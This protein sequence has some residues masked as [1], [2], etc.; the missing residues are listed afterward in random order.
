MKSIFLFIIFVLVDVLFINILIQAEYICSSLKPDLCIGL[1]LKEK[2][3]PKAGDKLQ[4]KSRYN[5]IL[6]GLAN[7]RL[8]W[9]LD[10]ANTN[11]TA[12][13]IY[14]IS[15]AE[16]LYIDH[17]QNSIQLREGGLF[18]KVDAWQFTLKSSRIVLDGSERCMTIMQCNLKEIGVVRPYCDP[19]SLQPEN[20]VDDLRKG[21]YVKLQPCKFGKE[22][23]VS[24][25]FGVGLDCEKGCNSTLRENEVCDEECNVQ[26]CFFDDGRCLN[27]Q[28]VTYTPTSS[29]TL[30]TNTSTNSTSSPVDDPP[31][32]STESP[33]GNTTQGTPMP[34]MQP[35]TASPE[36]ETPL[37]PTPPT[38]LPTRS[39]TRSPSKNP[40]QSPIKKKTKKPTSKP[41]SKGTS[42][43]G[44]TNDQHSNLN[45]E[46]VLIVGIVLGIVILILILI[47]ILL[48]VKRKEMNKEHE[49]LLQR[50][51][52]IEVEQSTQL[53]GGGIGEEQ[54]QD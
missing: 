32:N 25:S 23:K 11:D 2:E 48:L 36:Y 29:P 26:E 28:N 27:E 9:T 21:A 7:K 12:T 38:I 33:T 45:Y 37:P 3:S 35:V 4:L 20:N 47:L 13:N 8:N 49:Q 46:N 50:Q 14:L 22:G 24:Q 44:S 18:N 31:Y 19:N 34:T 43:N 51:L 17:Y 1:S 30:T 15:I 54:K 16:D 41:T 42:G 40:T 6:R 53:L 52:Q 5:T 39:P 10:D